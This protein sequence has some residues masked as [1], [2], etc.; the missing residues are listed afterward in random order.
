MINQ[1]LLDFIKQSLQQGSTKEKISSELLTNGWTQQ[2]I[3]EGFNTFNIKES[4]QLNNPTSNIQ[5]KNHSGRKVFLTIIILLLVGGASGYYFRNDIPVIKDLIRSKDLSVSEIKQE[6]NALNQIQEENNTKEDQEEQKTNPGEEIKKER[7]STPQVIGDTSFK[8]K[9]LLAPSCELIFDK[10]KKD[11]CYY[12]KAR[13]DKNVNFCETISS[14]LLKVDC[15]EQVDPSKITSQLCDLV[16]KEGIGVNYYNS[17]Y[18][19]L[20]VQANNVNFCKKIVNPYTG[21][22]VSEGG[23]SCL[24]N[25]AIKKLDPNVC[26]EIKSE[27]DKNSCLI[28]IANRTK[29]EETCQLIEDS[30][31]REDCV[32]LFK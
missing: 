9:K 8:D 14:I 10:E 4:N 27:Y 13:E 5:T 24:I 28:N 15:F 7:S 29:N 6:D 3:E 25:L 23:K 2:D 1:Q 20:A 16:P 31:Y 12:N 30:S 26:K 18:S 17:C 22:Y 19:Q 11:G 32:Y 21:E